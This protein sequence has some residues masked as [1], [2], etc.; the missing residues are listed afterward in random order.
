MNTD[1]S[2]VQGILSE[3]NTVTLAYLTEKWISTN[4]YQLAITL[5]KTIENEV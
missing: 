3:K 2:C 1:E 4:T 5:S